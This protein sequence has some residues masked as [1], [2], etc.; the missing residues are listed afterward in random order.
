M[1]IRSIIAKE[2]PDGIFTSDDL[3]AIQ[4]MK[5][6]EQIGKRIPEDLKLIGYDGSSFIEQYFSQ[7][8]TIK[9]PI[10][11]LASLLVDVL[12]KKLAGEETNKD[13]ILPISLL[14]GKTV[15][16]KPIEVSSSIGFWWLVSKQVV[17]HHQLPKKKASKRTLKAFFLID[18]KLA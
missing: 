2:N 12:M 13:Y 14:A 5:V 10:A 17:K 8:T 18:N 6:A 4:V 15:W 16:F 11:D 9:Q 1:E 7:L 3:T